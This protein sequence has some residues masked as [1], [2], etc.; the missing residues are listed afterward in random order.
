[1]FNENKQESRAR[2]RKFLFLIILG[3]LDESTELGIIKMLFL[4]VCF[5]SPQNSECSAASRLFKKETQKIV[6]WDNQKG[7]FCF[8]Y[9]EHCDTHSANEKSSL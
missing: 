8:T 9:N 2:G 4:F 6:C 5:L 3:I 7:V 1:M